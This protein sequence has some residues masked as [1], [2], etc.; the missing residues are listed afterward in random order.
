MNDKSFV[1]KNGANF[2]VVLR[3][4]KIEEE[5]QIIE[6]IGY[7]KLKIE[8]GSNIE[9][10]FFEIIQ[11]KEIRLVSRNSHHSRPSL[12]IRHSGEYLVAFSL[13]IT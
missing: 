1:V 10:F 4:F 11:P 2:N 5:R 6:E 13:E 3:L 8:N 7:V 12:K 9:E